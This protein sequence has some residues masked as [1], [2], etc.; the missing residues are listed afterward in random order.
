MGSGGNLDK[1]GK[2]QL[3]HMYTKQFTTLENREWAYTFQYQL[4]ITGDKP[5][6]HRGRPRFQANVHISPLWTRYIFSR[7]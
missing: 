7:V 5:I 2:K 6:T 3:I 1:E 4:N